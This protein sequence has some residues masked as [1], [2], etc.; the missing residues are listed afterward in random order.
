M[1]RK[2]FGLTRFPFATELAADEFFSF[3]AATELS[4]R[5]EHLCELRGIGLITGEVGAGKTSLCRNF[6]RALHHGIYRIFYVPNTTGNVM[7]LYKSIGH[8]RRITPRQE[9]GRERRAFGAVAWEIGLS[10][11]RSRA[12]LFRVIRAEVTRLCVEQKVLPILIIDEAHLLRADVLEDLRLLTNYNM[13]S[14]NR[15]CLLLI[16]QPELRRCLSMA[17]H[18]ALAQRIVVRY[19]ISGLA[20]DELPDYLT[21]RLRLAGTE[22]PLFDPPA[23]E[24]LFQI[25]GGKLRKIN[26]L[27][28]HCLFAAAADKAKSVTDEHVA[29]AR[30][31]VD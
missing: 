3:D 7:D 31:E 10:T 22:M 25:S 17:V 28:H 24:A 30:P 9:P 26:L 19:H 14:E 8:H 1:Y 27:A 11:V 23:Q 2:H 18:E 6:V 4:A 16:G 20:R 29:K 13:D 5:L 15:L 12:A 21:H